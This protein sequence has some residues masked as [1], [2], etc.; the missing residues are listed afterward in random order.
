MTRSCAAPPRPL[1][2]LPAGEVRAQVC[3]GWNQMTFRRHRFGLVEAPM[4][5][6]RSVSARS[7]RRQTRGRYIAVDLQRKT[8]RAQKKITGR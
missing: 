5:S 3:R 7:R 4:A 2:A 1:A 6:N 8:L